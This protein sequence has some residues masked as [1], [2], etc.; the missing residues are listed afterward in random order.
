MPFKSGYIAI[1]G[2][3]NVGKSTLLNRII[4][5]EVAIT[6]PK[7]QT[8]RHKI[9]GIHN[10]PGAQL[11]FLDTPGFHKSEK[12]I[13]KYMLG[14]IGGVIQ[15]ADVVCHMMEAKQ[16]PDTLDIELARRAKGKKYIIILN[17]I[18]RLKKVSVEAL[19]K[20]YQA[21]FP[22]A[23]VVST[24][25]VNGDGVNDLVDVI[26]DKL[27]E[28]PAYFRQDIF[29]EQPVRF[30]AAE[31]IRGEAMNLLHQ[32]IPYSIAV[33]IESFKEEPDITVIRAALIVEKNTHKGMLI[34]KNGQMIKKIGSL[35]RV[36]IESLVGT[37]VYLDLVVKVEKNW[38]KD[39]D[40]TK[41]ILGEV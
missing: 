32:E 35:A 3:P 5:E 20:H 29:T 13:N 40:M 28:G 14:V 23:Y 27:P 18:D 22:D 25:A 6:S 41:R 7:P 26:I 4:G 39:L 12:A 1:I 38:T 11:V 37:K 9:I 33:Q 16:E 30:M 2:Q 8:T 15:D 10:L 24:S 17:K 36:K 34:G 21:L 19:K 31:I